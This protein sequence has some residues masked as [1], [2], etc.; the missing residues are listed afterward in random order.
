[1]KP[2]PIEQVAFDSID[3]IAV[4]TQTDAGHAVVNLKPTAAIRQF[5]R[6]LATMLLLM[7]EH[8][9][10]SSLRCG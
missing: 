10:Q 4:E 1:M 5:I 8:V 9:P 2:V 7:R 6:E 3:N